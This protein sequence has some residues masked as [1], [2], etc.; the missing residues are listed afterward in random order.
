MKYLCLVYAEDTGSEDPNASPASQ[1]AYCEECALLEFE[2]ELV[3]S[4]HALSFASITP[5]ATT[6]LKVRHGSFGI[7]EPM[8]S[9]DR[10]IAC[11]VI[12]ARDL[13]EAIRVSGRMPAPRT[14]RIEVRPISER[15]S[16]VRP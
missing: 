3:R 14:L 12:Q 15:K 9:D 11:Y 4:G 2:D 10:L 6:I 8:R 13:N 7:A 16:G 5:T 1:S